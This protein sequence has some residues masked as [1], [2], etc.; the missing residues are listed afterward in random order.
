MKKKKYH[1]RKSRF[2]PFVLLLMLL[3]MG[4]T[5]HTKNIL[6]ENQDGYAYK[7]IRVESGDTLWSI[8]KDHGDQNM[9]PRQMIYDICQLNELDNKSIVIGQEIMVPISDL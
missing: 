9:D 5:N 3:I 2:V 6:N 7:V 8:V 4:T 1:I